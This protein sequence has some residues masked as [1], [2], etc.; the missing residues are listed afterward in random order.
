MKHS[1]Y[2]IAK[3]IARNPVKKN[4]GLVTKRQF[5]LLSTLQA[6]GAR[7]EPVPEGSAPVVFSYLSIADLLSRALSISSYISCRQSLKFCR[8]LSLRHIIF[9]L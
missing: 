8:P 1:P 3:L 5:F 4:N 7:W 2:G 6:A 9:D